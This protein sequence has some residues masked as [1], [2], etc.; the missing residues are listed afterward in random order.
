[1]GVCCWSGMHLC[2]GGASLIVVVTSAGAVCIPVARQGLYF[3]CR[4]SSFI[5][6]QMHVTRIHYLCP[7]EA[8]RPT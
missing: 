5:C 7:V 2:L 8:L 3:A 1:M 4:C 6:H